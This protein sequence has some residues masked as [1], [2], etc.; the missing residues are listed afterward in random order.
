M[1]I[2]EYNCKSEVS[3]MNTYSAEQLSKISKEEL[4]KEFFA[5]RSAI[6]SA[7]RSKT[8]AHELEIYFC[9]VSREL[10]L[11]SDNARKKVIK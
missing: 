6:N 7:K 1:Q 9:Y 2:K 10:Q 5:V 8:N 11:R 4:E 3:K